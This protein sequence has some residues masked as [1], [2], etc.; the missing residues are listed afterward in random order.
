LR[1]DPTDLAVIKRTLD[2]VVNIRRRVCNAAVF[3][4]IGGIYYTIGVLKQRERETT[5]YVYSN[6]NNDETFFGKTFPVYNRF[7]YS[8]DKCIVVII[9]WILNVYERSQK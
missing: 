2:E 3:Q 1:N 4:S 6:N 8:P 5:N 7:A 9:Q